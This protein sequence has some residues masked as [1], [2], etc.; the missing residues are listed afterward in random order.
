MVERIIYHELKVQQREE[1]SQKK[2]RS[3]RDRLIGHN[4]FQTENT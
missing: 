1:K 2:E 3:E 4:T